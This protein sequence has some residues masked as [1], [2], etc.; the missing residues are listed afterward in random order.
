M[1]LIDLLNDPVIRAELLRAFANTVFL[2]AGVTFAGVLVSLV[3]HCRKR[4]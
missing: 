3:R 1:R 2:F 4:P